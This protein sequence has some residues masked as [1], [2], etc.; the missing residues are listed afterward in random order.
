MIEHL[1]FRIKKNPVTRKALHLY[2]KATFT[3]AVSIPQIRP[4]KVKKASRD[5]KR[6]NL[7]I[8]SINEEHFFGG[9]ATAIRLFEEIM[10]QAKKIDEDVH[11]RIIATDARPKQSA[12]DNFKMYHHVLLNSDCRDRKQ[13]TSMGPERCPEILVT[14]GDRFIATAWWT[15]YTALEIITQQIALFGPNSQK[16]LYLIQDYEPSFYNWSTHYALAESTYQAS[17]P[18]VAVFNSS[19]LKAYFNNNR[20]H[21]LKEYVFEPRLSAELKRWLSREAHPREKTIIFYGRPSV[22]RNCFALIIEALRKWV[23]IQPD[24]KQWRILSVGEAH[25]P[26]DLGNN[27]TLQSMGKLSLPAYAKLMQTSAIGISLMI[28]PHPSYPPLEM[29]HFGL[30]T[31]T[32]TFGNKDLSK[33]H[34]NITSLERLTP[35][36]VAT[37]LVNLNQKFVADR[38]SGQNGKSLLPSYL[39]DSDQFPFIP[40]LLTHFMEKPKGAS[41]P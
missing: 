36:T 6:I 40:E 27:Q 32:N 38:L 31:L 25:P 33:C 18:T 24:H 34:Q 22:D 15:A 5:F 16:L 35:D 7:L 39:D 23:R 21:F 41:A 28:S 2:K 14:P 20:Y 30:L 19:Y 1:L 10:T 26:I 8:P 37:A 12:L 13:L 9:T 4:I 17:I 29:A 11:A 3:N